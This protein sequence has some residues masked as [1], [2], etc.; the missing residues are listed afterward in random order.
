MKNNIG[1]DDVIL[2]FVMLF[3]FGMAMVG[4]LFILPAWVD[5]YGDW[6]GFPIAVVWTLLPVI[7][8]F[9]LLKW[10]NEIMIRKLLTDV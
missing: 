5:R 4:G 9:D 10:R 7:L 1:L 8:A 3:M 6:V 2:M